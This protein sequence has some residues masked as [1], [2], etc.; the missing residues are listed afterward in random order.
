MT[1]SSSVYVKNIKQKKQEKLQLKPIKKQIPKTL[2]KPN[3][4]N[5]QEKNNNIATN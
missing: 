1:N 5:K 2:T 4:T 3:M